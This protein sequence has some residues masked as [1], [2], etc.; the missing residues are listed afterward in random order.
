[1]KSVALFKI[2]SFPE[3]FPNTNIS[4]TF[5]TVT[6][7]LSICPVTYSF[8]GSILYLCAA[9]FVQKN[10]IKLHTVLH[11]SLIIIFVP[12]KIGKSM[13]IHIFQF[14]LPCINSFQ[15]HSFYSPR[16]KFINCHLTLFPFFYKSPKYL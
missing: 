6:G 10:K 3:V 9:L 16:V 12:E 4:Q 1:M 15:Q 14:Q 2:I 5:I 8:K 7:L 11:Y 13:K